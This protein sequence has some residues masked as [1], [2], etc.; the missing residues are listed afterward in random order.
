MTR[1]TDD[2]SR[3]APH[4]T[5]SARDAAQLLTHLVEARPGKHVDV[6]DAELPPAI[7]LLR[8]WQA[9]RLAMTH[10]DLL[11]SPR[12]RP[13]T[14][15][16]LSDVYAPRDFSQRNYDIQKAYNAMRKAVPERVVH[17][18]AE[19]I[20]LHQFTDELDAKLVEALFNQLG[21]GEHITHEQYAEAYR[22]CDNYAD[23]AR[24]ID[25]IV[26][27]GRSVDRIVRLPFIGLTLRL[28]HTPAVLAGWHELQGFLER[29]YAA[30]KH[31]KG[32]EVFLSTIVTREMGILDRIYAGNSDPFDLKEQE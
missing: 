10:R 15:F 18:L 9:A 24:Q 7:R 2:I 6:E 5:P 23:R 28:A 26:R 32:A 14:L 4:A 8:E 31:M 17:V 13:A 21:V 29:G 25:M 16:F 27:I 22:I 30:F 19:T 1:E 12:Y 3:T 11:E 20:E